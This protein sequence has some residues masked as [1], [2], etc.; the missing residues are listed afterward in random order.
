MTLDFDGDCV[1]MFPVFY[2]ESLKEAAKLNP[3]KSKPI[4]LNLQKSDSQNFNLQLDCVSTI[5][6]ATKNPE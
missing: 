2:K 5:Y 6:S 3:R 1:A 4:W